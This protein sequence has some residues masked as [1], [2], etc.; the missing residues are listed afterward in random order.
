M[1]V[2]TYP[3]AET[4]RL[5]VRG[6][7]CRYCGQTVSADGNRFRHTATGQYRC[8]PA[9]RASYEKSLSDSFIRS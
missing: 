8:E 2:N 5:G 7:E 1:T 9:K 6:H 3:T 4:I